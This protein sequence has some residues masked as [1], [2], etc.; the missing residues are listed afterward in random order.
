VPMRAY[1]FRMVSGE[2]AAAT[3]TFIRAAQQNNN[4]YRDAD[5]FQGWE[6]GNSTAIKVMKTGWVKIFF[7]GY[8]TGVTANAEA[9]AQIVYNGGGLAEAR[10]S[11]P[12]TVISIGIGPLLK[13]CNANDTIQ[14]GSNGSGS[15]YQGT[16]GRFTNGWLEYM[17]A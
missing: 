5:Y 13:L 4:T 2:A 6:A 8:M 11:S 9:R 14:F 7:Q 12:G 15:C 3:G 1:V 16:D 10:V 17:G